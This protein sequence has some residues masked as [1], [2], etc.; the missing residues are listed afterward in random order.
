M[1]MRGNKFKTILYLYIFMDHRL[2]NH[3][4]LRGICEAQISCC[5]AELFQAADFGVLKLTKRRSFPNRGRWGSRFFWSKD[6]KGHVFLA[7]FSK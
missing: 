4:L 2:F 3:H 5:S 7:L 6:L 1:H